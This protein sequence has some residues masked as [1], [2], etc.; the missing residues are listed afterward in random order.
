[1]LNIRESEFVT[2]SKTFTYTAISKEEKSIDINK[3]SLCFTYCQVPIVY[4]NTGKESIKIFFIDN[5]VIEINELILDKNTSELIF[6]R[7][8]A[9]DKIEVSVK[10]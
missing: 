2:V 1:M 4:K 5:S 7:T 6:E 10:I 9:I 3:G 8:G